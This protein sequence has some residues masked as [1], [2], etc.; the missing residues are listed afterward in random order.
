ML[1]HRGNPI[2]TRLL[3]TPVRGGVLTLTDREL[4]LGE[5]WLG[6]KNVRRFALQSLAQLELLSESSAHVPQRG[7]LLRFTWA[8]GQITDVYSVGPVAAKRI[9]ESLPFRAGSPGA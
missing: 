9:H 7:L 1:N 8:D 6:A 2:M 4:V 5:G 3:K